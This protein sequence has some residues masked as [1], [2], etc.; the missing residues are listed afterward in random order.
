MESDDI[1]LHGADLPRDQ[2]EAALGQAL[3]P[4]VPGKEQYLIASDTGSGLSIAQAFL[5]LVSRHLL[6]MPINRPILSPHLEY[7][8]RSTHTAYRRQRRLMIHRNTIGSSM[9]SLSIFGQ[10]LRETWKLCGR[11]REHLAREADIT[12]AESTKSSF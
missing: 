3:I 12:T 9:A 1:W 2:I 4:N 11:T 7:A 6:A 5:G 8:S 10:R